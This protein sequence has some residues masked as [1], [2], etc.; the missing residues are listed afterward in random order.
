MA[1]RK[2]ILF[3]DDEPNILQGIRR[4]LHK[5]RKEWHIL[6]ASSGAEALDIL[7]TSECDVVVTDMKMPQMDGAEFLNRVRERHPKISRIV[8]S[9]QSDPEMLL[10]SVK[11]AQQYLSKPCDSDQ[12]LAVIKRALCL[13]SKLGDKNLLAAVSSIDTLPS[14]PALYHEIVTLSH[15][16]KSTIN[17]IGEV[18][19]KD[20][21]MSAKILQLV[22]SAFFGMPQHVSQ[23]SQAVNLLG[24][25]TV[26]ALVLTIN[27]FDEFKSEYVDTKQMDKLFSHS[28]TVANAAKSFAW[29]EGADKE[30]I[31]FTYLAGLLHDVGK[32]IIWCKFPAQ[33]AILN[34]RMAENDSQSSLYEIER[35]ML[36]ATHAEL[37]AYLMGLWGMNNAIVE[38]LADHHQPSRSNNPSFAPLTAVYA[39]NYF[40]HELSTESQTPLPPLD[41]EYIT[42]LGLWERT[43]D[44]RNQLKSA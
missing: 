3:V 14:V 15:S 35:Q 25:D 27:V 39:A 43:E 40:V 2:R 42:G 6:F 41:R 21:A 12:L 32:L 37:G 36:G 18:I 31:D 1:N 19:A 23:P 22:N 4:M 20:M 16:D 30:F 38:A 33:Y 10:R 24:L 8:L 5:K 9:G 26:K 29:K 44:W 17:Q 34:T 7:S 13:K 11:S 28:L